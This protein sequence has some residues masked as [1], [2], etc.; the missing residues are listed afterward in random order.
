MSECL[1]CNEKKKEIE[2]LKGELDFH[3]GE[4]KRWRELFNEQRGKETFNEMQKR[5]A[6]EIVD[7][8]RLRN[9]L[10]KRNKDNEV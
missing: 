2:S 9:E 8:V 10:K 4:H 7:N 6:D 3:K 1:A 5:Y